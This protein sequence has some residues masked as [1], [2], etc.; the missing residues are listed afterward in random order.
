MVG[1]IWRSREGEILEC[2]CRTDERLLGVPK[3]TAGFHGNLG[4]ILFPGLTGSDADLLRDIPCGM[5]MS[6]RPFSAYESLKV[7]GK[8]I[9]PAVPE[10]RRAGRIST[11]V[12]LERSGSPL[13]WPPLSPIDI[14]E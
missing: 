13:Y 12:R 2:S 8:G 3:L 4:T 6:L 9:S 14:V 5:F 7:L 1:G 11:T 10:S